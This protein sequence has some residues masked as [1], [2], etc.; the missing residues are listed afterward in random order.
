MKEVDTLAITKI[1][2]KKVYEDG[3]LF[4]KH[5]DFEE[6]YNETFNTKEK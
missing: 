6:Y 3:K 4:G 5:V 1:V 2:L